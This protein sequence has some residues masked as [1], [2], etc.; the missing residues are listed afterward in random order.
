MNPRN[1]CPSCGGPK[2]F[3]AKT[4]RG[5]CDT[6][7]HGLSRT[8]EYRAWQTMRLR[9]TVPTNPAY[10]DYGGRGIT[11]CARWLASVSDFVADMG[12][13]PS[14]RHELDRAKND[15]GY[16]CGKC[17]ECSRLARP[18]NCRWVTRS[19]ND[20][21]RRSSRFLE[22]R[23]ERKTLVEW[24][25]ILGLPHATVGKRLEAGWSA[26]KALSTPVRPK[27]PNGSRRA[28]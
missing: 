15:L 10:S 16:W 21:N 22:Y 2:A 20:R 17:E 25:E 27:A 6:S 13:K 11:V 3:Y 5:C 1:V 18:A 9:C 14:A 26:E 8:P 12:P 7:E 4:C 28:A 24:C 19:V 23:G